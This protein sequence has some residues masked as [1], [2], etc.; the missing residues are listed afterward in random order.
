[1]YL[2]SSGFYWKYMMKSLYFVP[3]LALPIMVMAQSPVNELPPNDEQRFLEIKDLAVA[4]D[5]LNQDNPNIE[6][7]RAMPLGS[8]LEDEL[9]RA[10]V[11]K[12]WARLEVLLAKYQQQDNF[13]QTL[14]DYALG[15][16]HRSQGRHKQAIK[17]YQNV[18][19]DESL[20]YP[21]FDL[22]VMLFEDK[23]YRAA[24]QQFNKV[25]DKL[26]AQMQTI[27]RQYRN[28]IKR[29]ERVQPRLSL[30]YEETDNVNN[31]SSASIIEING[32][33]FIK[34]SD[35]MPQSAHGV[36]YEIGASKDTNIGG[37]HFIVADVD[38]DGVAY[39]DMPTYDEVTLG[40]RFGYAN[41]DVKRY[42]HIIPF[43]EQNWLE[44]DKYSRHHGISATYSFKVLPDLQM[45]TSFSH[46][47]KRYE[48]DRTAMRH[49]G[50]VNLGSLTLSKQ[51]GNRY[52]AYAGFDLSED[53]VKDLSESSER[54]GVR[55]GLAH[56]G[57]SFG[58]RVM[59][60]Y[61]KRDF[62]A[63]NFW[64]DE[65]RRDKEY[66]VN[67][68]MWYN[69]ISYKG[70]TPSLNYRYQKINSNLDS[71]YSRSSQAIFVSLERSF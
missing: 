22:A 48:N 3:A 30:N 25:Y 44:S 62:L 53:K 7:D 31:A 33:K 12:D 51:L 69:P 32:A 50:R 34:D 57:E 37:N 64:Y 49:D 5:L 4:D 6:I 46:T 40:A 38:V 66:Q 41:R 42:W 14:Y 71:M 60:R 11:G 16:M 36:R 1:M 52:V 58:G 23:Q 70:F 63:D 61:A 67:A 19:S 2:I 24:E 15:A 29:A 39:W 18:T 20:V 8:T 59:M 56:Y 47:Q 35:S 45:S 68:A 26:P 17:L 43:V 21:S 27:I 13:D 54:R 28:A 65:I 55:L 9:T 10:L